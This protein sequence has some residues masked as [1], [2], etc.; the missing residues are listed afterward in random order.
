LWVHLAGVVFTRGVFICLAAAAVVLLLF[1][2]WDLMQAHSRMVMSVVCTLLFGAVACG[3]RRLT[4]IFSLRRQ[5]VRITVSQI[6]V[7]AGFGL[8]LIA[9]I[10]IWQIDEVKDMLAITIIGGVL[11]IMFQDTIKSVVAFFYVRIHHLVSIGDWIIVP[12]QGIDGKVMSITLTTVTVENWDTTLST[13][14]TNLLQTSH[15]QNLQ[16]MADGKTHGR[17]VL[18]SFVIDTGWI[19]P[20]HEADIDRIAAALDGSDAFVGSVLRRRVR[21]AEATGRPV[22]NAELFRFYMHH[23][24]MNHAHISRTPRL[25]VRWLEPQPEGLPLQI[26]TYIIDSSLEDFEWQQSAIVEH[27]LAAMALFNLQL[28]QSASG[29]D[30]SNSNVFIADHEATYKHYD[31]GTQ[32]KTL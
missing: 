15:F 22:L 19:Q 12:S 23:W 32:G 21:E 30:A 8:W 27:L 6:C 20:M 18:R 9:L 24:L 3:V 5:E 13:F 16:R 26:Y 1:P 2:R 14:P 4:P 17:R 29:Y 10:R 11:S 28:F 7:L 31:D 25:L